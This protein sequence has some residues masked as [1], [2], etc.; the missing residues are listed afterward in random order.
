[1]L[2]AG[3]GASDLP[4]AL[5]GTFAT[6]GWCGAAAS[7]FEVAESRFFGPATRS[8]KGRSRVAGPQNDRARYS[9]FPVPYSLAPLL[10][11]AQE[12]QPDHPR[13]VALEVHLRLVA[14]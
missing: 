8:A 10:H 6:A 11:P 7:A 14:D 2:V 4:H 3:R 13:P 9:L 1:M 5:A 12:I